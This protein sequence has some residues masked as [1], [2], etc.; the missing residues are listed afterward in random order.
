[1][2]SAGRRSWPQAAAI[3]EVL[4]A[5]WHSMFTAVHPRP[6]IAVVLCALGAAEATIA[7]RLE[8]WEL[9]DSDELLLGPR[10]GGLRRTGR[11]AQQRPTM[12]AVIAA[13]DRTEDLDLLD[14]LAQT[15]DV[16]ERARPVT[17]AS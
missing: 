5:L 3:A 14:L 12:E 10:L 17:P 13:F 16:L 11:V 15:H 9:L 4:D 1:M 7:A 2:R 6:G 8:E